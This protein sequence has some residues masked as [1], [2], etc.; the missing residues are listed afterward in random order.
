[1]LTIPL[2]LPPF[3]FFTLFYFNGSPLWRVGAAPSTLPLLFF[4]CLSCSLSFCSCCASSCCPPCFSPPMLSTH[5]LVP[6]RTQS[7]TTLP[8]GSALGI[9]WASLA[10]LH[11]QSPHCPHPLRPVDH[12]SSCPLLSCLHWVSHP[13]PFYLHSHL[14]Q[15]DMCPSGPHCLDSPLR[16]SRWLPPSHS[17]LRQAFAPSPRSLVV[18]V[19]NILSGPLLP[20]TSPFSFTLLPSLLPRWDQ[21]L[22]PFHPQRSISSFTLSNSLLP[23]KGQ[24]SLTFSTPAIPLEFS[25]APPP[26]IAISPLRL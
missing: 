5:T 21:P 17:C 18:L 4:K 16:V 1:M 25:T 13:L 6:L 22:W 9:E 11:K 23:E 12:R 7:R 2:F 10:P 3:P 19:G 24:V 15:E 26:Q 14:C 8:R 20:K